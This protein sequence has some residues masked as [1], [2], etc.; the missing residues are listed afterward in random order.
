MNDHIQNINRYCDVAIFSNH[1]EIAAPT[2]RNDGVGDIEN[3]RRGGSCA[4]PN[5]A[6]AAIIDETTSP[7]GTQGKQIEELIRRIEKLENK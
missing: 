5:I 7:F 6:T 1:N 2:A 4:L 3:V